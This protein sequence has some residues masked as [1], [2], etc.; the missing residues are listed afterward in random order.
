[1]SSNI[2][3][4]F[5]LNYLSLK[6]DVVKVHIVIII[7]HRGNYTHNMVEDRIRSCKYADISNIINKIREKLRNVNI[8]PMQS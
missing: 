7:A 4:A 8:Y 6:T 3:L 2:R 5:V 1:M